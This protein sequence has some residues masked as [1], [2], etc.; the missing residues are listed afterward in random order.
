MAVM[1]EAVKVAKAMSQRRSTPIAGPFSL[2]KA[3]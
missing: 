2:S 3:H 1:G